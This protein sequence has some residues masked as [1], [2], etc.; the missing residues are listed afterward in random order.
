M[1]GINVLLVHLGL[2]TQ[3]GKNDLIIH[4][5]IPNKMNYLEDFISLECIIVKDDET[6][7]AGCKDI[8]NKFKQYITDNYPTLQCSLNQ[9]TV[10]R[11]IRSLYPHIIIKPRGINYL[12]GIKLINQDVKSNRRY[13]ERSMDNKKNSDVT[14]ERLGSNGREFLERLGLDPRKNSVYYDQLIKHDLLRY[15][16]NE[17]KTIDWNKTLQLTNDKIKTFNANN[18]K[19]PIFPDVSSTNKDG[20]SED[21]ED[22]DEFSISINKEEIDSSDED[23]PSSVKVNVHNCKIPIYQPKKCA[24]HRIAMLV[25]DEYVRTLN[26]LCRKTNAREKDPVK[27]IA[28]FEEITK[29]RNEAREKWKLFESQSTK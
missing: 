3:K 23:N 17:D 11:K 2:V 21:D 13:R 25:Y 24:T 19:S 28:I 14:S 16:Y 27:K 10:T 6:A 12:V 8:F 4:I 1:K 18:N 22:L 7:E 29:Q 9:G 26:M 15:G 5:T 20:K